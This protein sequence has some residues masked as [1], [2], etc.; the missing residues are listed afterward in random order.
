V[1]A[2]SPLPTWRCFLHNHL[3]DIAAIDM[4]VV[5]KP[6]LLSD[7]KQMFEQMKSVVG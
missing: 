2:Q 7:V 3:T 1:A 4:F 5:A 6:L